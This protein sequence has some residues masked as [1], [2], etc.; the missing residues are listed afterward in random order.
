MR[1]AGR[2]MPSTSPSDVPVT[3]AMLSPMANGQIVWPVARMSSP[4]AVSS[5]NAAATL[6]G[7]GRIIGET[8]MLTICHSTMNATADSELR[9]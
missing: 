6:P 2:K 9:T 7:D 8:F 5:T 3:K 1:A 4:E